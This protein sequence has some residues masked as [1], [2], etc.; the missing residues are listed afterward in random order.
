MNNMKSKEHEKAPSKALQKLSLS[1]GNFIRYWG[2]RRIHGAI[3][4]QLYVAT[5]PLSCT[6]LVER[7][8]VSKALVSPALDELCVYELIY[9]APA[10]NDKTKVYLAHENLSEVIRRVLKNR[11]AQILKEI[12]ADFSAF[13]KKDAKAEIFDKRRVESL[14]KMISAATLMLDI[15][16]EQD[17]ILDLP[18]E[19][20]L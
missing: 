14:E 1:I 4:T 2:F 11:E 15:I 20:G 7:L 9:A 18:I 10:P 12:T 19:L 13:A 17:D 8:G 5:R 16:L 6:D 3:W